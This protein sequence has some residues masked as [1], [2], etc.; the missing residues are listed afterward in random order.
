MP[1]TALLRTSAIL[2][3]QARGGPPDL[4][5]EVHKGSTKSLELPGVK[6]EK[7][8]WLTLAV[9][10]V[11]SIF[12]ESGAAFPTDVQLHAEFKD[13]MSYFVPMR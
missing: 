4:L 12:P 1:L 3:T 11:L 10:N 13:L 9:Q 2:E 8:C 5:Y 6:H 7:F